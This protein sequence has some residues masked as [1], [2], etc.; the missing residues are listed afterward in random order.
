M[1]IKKER[2]SGKVLSVTDTY[3]EIEGYG[4]IPLSPSFHVYKTY[5]EFAVLGAEDIL[6]GY[7]LQE[8]VAGRGG[9]VRGSF[10]AGV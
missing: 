8:F 9:T 7:D 3:I 2:I 5:G 10:G 6:V 4:Q 1:T